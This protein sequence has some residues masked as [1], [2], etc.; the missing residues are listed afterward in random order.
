M[1]YEAAEMRFVDKNGAVYVEWYD[2]DG[3]CVHTEDK[4]LTNSL[5]TMDFSRDTKRVIKVWCPDGAL[6]DT[7]AAGTLAPY[8]D[9]AQAAKEKLPG[10]ITALEALKGCAAALGRI[11]APVD[12]LEEV[13]IP[14]KA[15]K[16]TLQDVIKTLEPEQEEQKK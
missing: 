1:E 12:M 5:D 3:H 7:L 10:N 2:K 9:A 13:L 16:N 11:K 14:L 15:V 6:V 8:W 4:Y